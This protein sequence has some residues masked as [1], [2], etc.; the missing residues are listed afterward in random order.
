MSDNAQ[1]IEE[2]RWQLKQIEDRKAENQ[3]LLAGIAG[4]GHTTVVSPDRSVTVLAGPD[5]V[6]SEVR[7]APEAMRFDAVTLSRTITAAVREAV[8]AGVKPSAQPP[9]QAAP[10]RPP[11]P[12]PADDDPYDTVFDI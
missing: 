5:G 12:A 2:M 8:A 6:V 10:R 9:R 3:R 7:L 4:S 11:Q 1:L